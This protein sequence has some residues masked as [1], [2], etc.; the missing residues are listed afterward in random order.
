MDEVI[1]GGRTGPQRRRNRKN[2]WTKA[3][4]EAFLAELAQSCNI[5]RASE[6]AGLTQS[7]A[8]RLRQRDPVFAR[9]WQ[10]A[11]TLGYERL[12]LAL[13]RRAL[14]VIDGMELDERAEQVEKMTVAQA[15]DVLRQHRESV[16]RGQARG[17]RPQG[18]Q[19][20]TQEETDAVLLKRIAMIKRQRARRAGVVDGGELVALPAA[21][22]DAAKDDGA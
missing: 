21:D 13:L 15:I 1:E 8:Y 10:E 16:L 2:G 11:L 6:I 20:A 3:R 7:G 17:R 5:R 19:V 18:R 12:E 4:R 22:P 14:E 9:Q